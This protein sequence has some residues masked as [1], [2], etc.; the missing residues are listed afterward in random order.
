M[1]NPLRNGINIQMKM[2]IL[3]FKILKFTFRQGHWD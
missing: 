3:D 1:V 2:S